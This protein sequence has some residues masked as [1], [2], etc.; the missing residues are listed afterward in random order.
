MRPCFLRESLTFWV[1]QYGS[2]VA[3]GV[4]H[5]VE[6]GST[7]AA[8]GGTRDEGGR[9]AAATGWG[10]RSVGRRW[11]GAGGRLRLGASQSRRKATSATP[12]GG[13]SR[14][15]RASSWASVP[16]SGMTPHGP[17][18]N[19]MHATPA[20]HALSIEESAVVTQNGTTAPVLAA[21]LPM[22]RGTKEL[23][24]GLRMKRVYA[25]TAA[26]VPPQDDACG[27]EQRPRPTL[28][29]PLTEV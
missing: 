9:P 1:V 7:T 25:E 16:L 4:Y 12:R 8:L 21:R 28:Y 15:V 18:S 23:R 11:G 2:G 6:K 5:D 22:N 14:S 3:A 26:R 29:R 10:L 20:R 17:P 19:P 27:S 24:R 13:A